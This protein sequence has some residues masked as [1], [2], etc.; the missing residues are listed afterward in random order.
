MILPIVLYGNPVLKTP[1]KEVQNEY[2]D[3]RDLL[4]NMWDTMYHAKGVGLAAPQIGLSIRIF[5]VDSTAYYD[6]SEVHKGIKK[7]FINPKI[8]HEEGIS[9]GFEEGCLSIP[10]I[11]AEVLR[12]PVLKIRYQDELFQWKEEEYDDMN[13]RIIQHEYDHIEGILFVEKISAIRKKLIQSK[14][15]KI[16]RGIVDVKY[17][18][19]Q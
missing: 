6:K 2:K 3:L 1:A 16:K 18:V 12:K 13:A 9:W 15:E 11:N 8:I 14:L 4:N 7:V 10:K 19:R 17:P 5:I